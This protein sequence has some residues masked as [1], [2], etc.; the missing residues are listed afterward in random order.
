MLNWDFITIHVELN[1][2][3]LSYVQELSKTKHIIIANDDS[4]RDKDIRYKPQFLKKGSGFE[5][6]HKKNHLF[7]SEV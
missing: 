7:T 3:S 4:V 2:C 6:I 1:N 5:A